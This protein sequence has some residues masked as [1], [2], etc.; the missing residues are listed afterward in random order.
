MS[1]LQ[2]PG[3]ISIEQSTHSAMANR[4]LIRF[5]ATPNMHNLPRLCFGMKYDKGITSNDL[6][7]ARLH[8]LLFLNGN[9]EQMLIISM[10]M[11]GEVAAP[12]MFLLFNCGGG[13]STSTYP[14]ARG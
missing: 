14:P 3:G 8:V 2:Q 6:V 7:G 10:F 4:S 1:E 9:T 5:W 11:K 12:S 13:L